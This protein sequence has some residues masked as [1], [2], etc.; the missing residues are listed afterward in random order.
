M[1][2]DPEIPKHRKRK[3]SAKKRFGVQYKYLGPRRDAT[4]SPLDL[5]LWGDGGI[6]W[7]VT[8]AAAEQSL[9]RWL[10]GRNGFATNFRPR[11]SWTAEIVV[12]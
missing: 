8:K 2:T 5:S 10:D 1:K 7:F 9:Q 11:G 12:R 6:E 3:P 4:S